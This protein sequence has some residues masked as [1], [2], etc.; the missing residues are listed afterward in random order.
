MKKPTP[1]RVIQ[2][3]GVDTEE[4]GYTTDRLGDAAVRFIN[5]NQQKP[6]FLFL[7]FTAPHGPLQARKSDL[8]K[9]AHITPVKR[10]KY[11]GLVK[12]LDDNVGKVLAALEAAG[13]AEDTLVVFTN[14]NG[15]QTLTGANNGQLRGRK[16]SLLEGGIRVPMCM[17]WPGQ[18]EAD[19][20][21]HDPVI[22]LDFFPTFLAIGG[23]E[24]DPKWALDGINLLPRLTGV[25]SE[26][27][28]RPLYWRQGKERAVRIGNH[29]LYIA[30]FA[31]DSE[32]NV[33]DLSDDI[34][35]AEPL[36]ETDEQVAA[37]LN[38]ALKTFENAMV[39]PKWGGGRRAKS[40]KGK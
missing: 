9:L 38:S 13:L 35:E 22:S 27:E 28:Q 11:A 34:G 5:E 33:F 6:F 32:R 24:V 2:E 3:N 8:E 20:K 17:R 23:G 12:A 16:G 19:T 37:A 39:L 15:G 4:G 21:I 26:L 31:G 14:D 18:I 10:R 29:K 30:D 36:K 40:S 25:V 7:S 1:H